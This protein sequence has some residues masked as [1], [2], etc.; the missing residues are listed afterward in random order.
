[1]PWQVLAASVVLGAGACGAVAGFNFVRLGKRQYLAP[2]VLIGAALFV[3]V[4]G[5]AI[6]LVPDEFGRPVGPLANLAV[7]LGFMLAQKPFFDGWKAGNWRPKPGDKYRPNGLGQLLLIGL[8]SLGIE[9]G[10]IAFFATLG[11]IW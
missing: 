9:V 3:A 4:A 11:G 2:S 1:M 10:V 8:V 6:F 5:L 7:G